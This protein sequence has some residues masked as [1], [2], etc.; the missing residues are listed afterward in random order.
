MCDPMTYFLLF[1]NGDDGWH[2]IMPY[3]TTTRRERK[4]AAA[5]AM[6]VNEEE[7]INPPRFNEILRLEN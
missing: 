1:H 5:G 3:T 2:V 6:N 4:E 7:E